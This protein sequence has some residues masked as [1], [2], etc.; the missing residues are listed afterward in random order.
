MFSLKSITS[1]IVITTLGIM[2]SF[3][4]LKQ[5]A[6]VSGEELKQ[7]ASA[8]QEVQSI[9]QVAQKKMAKTVQEEG[10][11][12]QRFNEIQKA[13]QNPKKDAQLTEE[14][15]KQYKSATM[16]IQKIQSKSQKKMQ[17][18]IVEEGLSVNRYQEIAMALQKD[19]EL[20]KRI[21]KYIEG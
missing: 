4:Q 9:N 6:G 12:V 2:S 15:Q 14:E 20:Q 5:T 11:G 21:Q 16:E 19:P 1:F 17:A 10:L 8:F 13:Q 3:A 7:F 18:K